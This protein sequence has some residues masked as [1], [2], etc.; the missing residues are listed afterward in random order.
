MKAKE[1]MDKGELVPDELINQML[2]E[3]LNSNNVKKGFIL[4]GYPR[5]I[6]QAQTLE[7]ILHDNNK[8]LVIYL[9]ASEPVI[10]SRLSGRRVCGDCQAVF[11]LKNMP[12]RKDEICDFCGGTL[13]QR[14][15]DKEETI[16]RRLGVYLKETSSLLDYYDKKNK[17]HKIC[18]DNDA[19]QVLEEMLGLIS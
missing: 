8:E 6:V 5:N 11:H 2:K 4:D 13:H 12:P 10:V 1:F 15:D 17:L 19:S 7:Q 3:R 9:H 18:A 14:T 16:K